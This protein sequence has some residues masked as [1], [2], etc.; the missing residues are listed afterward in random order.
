MAQTLKV[1]L[2]WPD[3]FKSNSLRGMFLGFLGFGVIL[4]VWFHFFLNKHASI[5]RLLAHH[6]A[7]KW[8]Y[9]SN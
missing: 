8:D 3:F 6:F 5:S 7:Q 1:E 4:L 9:K 2:L